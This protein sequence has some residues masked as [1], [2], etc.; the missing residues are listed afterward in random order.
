MQAQI[1][2][3][4]VGMQLFSAENEHEDLIVRNLLFGSETA[5][6]AIHVG[7]G[8]YGH[9]FYSMYSGNVLDLD[10]QLSHSGNGSDNC[11]HLKKGKDGNYTYAVTDCVN[12]ASYFVCQK[13]QV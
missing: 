1:A 7:V 11:L 9:K 6:S 13:I 5:P 8:I 4:T 10:T 3:K 12:I 2:C